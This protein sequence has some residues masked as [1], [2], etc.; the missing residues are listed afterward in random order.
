VEPFDE[1]NDRVAIRD[2]IVRCGTSLDRAD[3]E[4]FAAC[5]GA[6]C[7]TSF[8]GNDPGPGAENMLA[9]FRRRASQ[10]PI[11]SSTHLLG[12]IFVEVE[13][14]RGRAESYAVGYLVTANPDGPTLRMRGLR[15]FDQLCCD[16]KRSWLIVDRVVKAD[17]QH[18]CP[19]SAPSALL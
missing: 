15:Y 18:V 17:W 7:H 5:F 12:N 6:D 9:Y 10:S 4:T 3:W 14:E 2:L 11:L 16:R 1:R 8:D 13:G 19:V